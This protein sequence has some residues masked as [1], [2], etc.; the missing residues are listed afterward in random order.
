M[1]FIKN[2]LQMCLYSSNYET[3][4]FLEIS[5]KKNRVSDTFYISNDSA[6]VIKFMK[7]KLNSTQCKKCEN[8]KH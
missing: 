7:V 2:F 1:F 5:E 8:A 6:N 3:Y 4:L